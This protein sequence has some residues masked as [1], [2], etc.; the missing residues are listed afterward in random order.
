MNYVIVKALKDPDMIF[1]I[2]NRK[3]EPFTSEVNAQRSM[4]RRQRNRGSKRYTWT[5]MKVDA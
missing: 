4:T 3:G 1:V 5:I 2:G